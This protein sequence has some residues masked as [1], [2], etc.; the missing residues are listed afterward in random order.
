MTEYSVNIP[1]GRVHKMNR[2]E[3]RIY[4]ALIFAVALP[5][6]LIAWMAKP[7]L[8]GKLPNYGPLTIAHK[9]ASAITPMIFRA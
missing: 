8:T 7:V 1:K 4:F 9:D 3:Y 2:I 6:A 5:F